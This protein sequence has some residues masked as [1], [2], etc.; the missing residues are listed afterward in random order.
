MKFIITIDVEADNLWDKSAAD[1]VTCKNISALRKFCDLS[2]RYGFPTT[3]LVSYEVFDDPANSALLK[4]LEN[5]GK[6]EIGAHLH[7]WLTPPVYPYDSTY[8]SYPSDLSYDDLY[9]KLACLTEKIEKSVQIKPLS[10]RSGRWGF[11]QVN[12]EVLSRLG[13]LVDCSVTPYVDWTQNKGGMGPGSDYF[14]LEPH[15]FFIETEGGALLEVPVTIHL[16]NRWLYSI[17]FIQRMMHSMNRTSLGKNAA[18][19]MG[20]RQQWLRPMFEHQF[21]TYKNIYEKSCQMQ[22]PVI[23]M[24]FHSSELMAETNNRFTDDAKVN[25]VFQSFELFFSFLKDHHVT[26]ETLTSYYHETKK[27]NATVANPILESP[28]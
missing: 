24:M 9:A 15:P 18:K 5:E 7:P 3:L 1:K 13:Y 28:Y 10:Y 23:E 11:N 12:A 14:H 17:P 19:A 4:D 25:N 6:C 21:P 2:Y 8:K 16:R 22:L 26:G 20:L 27:S